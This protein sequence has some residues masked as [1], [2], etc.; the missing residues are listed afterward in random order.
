M[1]GSANAS[2]TQIIQ[3]AINP[4][5]LASGRTGV[6]RVR[7]FGFVPMLRRVCATALVLTEYLATAEHFIRTGINEQRV[8]VGSHFEVL[9]GSA[10]VVV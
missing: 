4:S 2:G 5:H 8:V 10:L 9:R 6:G 7:G 3:G 1:A